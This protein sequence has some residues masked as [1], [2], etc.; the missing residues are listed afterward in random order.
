MCGHS[1]VAQLLLFGLIVSLNTL[2]LFHPLKVWYHT[3][4][5]QVTGVQLAKHLQKT[6]TTVIYEQQF[7]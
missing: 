4:I 6:K 7:I 1:T 2:I 5:F 3:K